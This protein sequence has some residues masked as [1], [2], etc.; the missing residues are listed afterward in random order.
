MTSFQV[1]LKATDAY[2]ITVGANLTVSRL[3]LKNV[4]IFHQSED[5]PGLC[6]VFLTPAGAS[7]FSN[8]AKFQRKS[9]QPHDCPIVSQETHNLTL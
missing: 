3:Q 9:G 1:E 6:N 7:I 4:T 8:S 2:G 5:K